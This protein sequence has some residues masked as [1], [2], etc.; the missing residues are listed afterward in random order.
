MR[1]TH[2]KVLFGAVGLLAITLQGCV[3]SSGASVQFQTST[4]QGATPVRSWKDLRDENVVFQ[5]FDYSCGAAA[6]ATLMRYYFG[7]DTSEEMILAGILGPMTEVELRDREANG[8]SLLDLDTYAER[9]GYQA[10]SARLSYGSLVELAGPVIVY[11]EEEDYRHFAVLKGVQGDRIYLADPSLGNVRLSIDR[12]VRQWS[13]VA[14]VLGKPGF[15]LP[16]EYPLAVED[17]ESVPNET[18]A[19]RRSLFNR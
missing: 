3:A 12:F 6:L 18:L 2:R 16:T 7:D 4:L 17:Q 13:G 8:L 1:G 10:V 19:A 9:A 15:G 11:L 5:R 14:L